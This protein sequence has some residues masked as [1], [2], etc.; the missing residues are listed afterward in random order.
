MQVNPNAPINKCPYCGS[1]WGYYTKDYIHGSTWYRC[2]FDGTE[3][4]NGDMYDPLTHEAGK[5]AYC[6]SCNKR[7]FKMSE[8][9][10]AA[11]K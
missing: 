9:E 10:E 1:D 3:A 8:L 4:D 6:L 2:N 11:E 7:L 5:Y